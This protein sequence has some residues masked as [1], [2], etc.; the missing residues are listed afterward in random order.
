MSFIVSNVVHGG[1][2]HLEIVMDVVTL[3]LGVH[4]GIRHLE[5]NLKIGESTL[6]V[7][8]GIRHL[9]SPKNE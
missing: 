7:H 4:G 6:S 5:R 9:E 2:R 1:I 3:C 8:G